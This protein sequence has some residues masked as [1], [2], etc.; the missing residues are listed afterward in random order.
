LGL[1]KRAVIARRILLGWFAFHFCLLLAVSCREA[2]WVV[3][4]GLTIFPTQTDRLWKSAEAI[5]GAGLGERLSLSN[6]L[7]QAVAGYQHMAG[8]ESGYGFF[9]PNVTNGYQLAFKIDY[10]D[11]HSD[12]EV[13]SLG[14]D[15]AGI[16]FAGLL[17]KIGRTSDGSMGETM[18]RMLT[19][20]KWR[21]HPKAIKIH[22]VFREV[23][24]PSAEEYEQGGRESYD[25]LGEYDFEHRKRPEQSQQKQL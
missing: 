8:I 7:R 23:G 16:R 21:E 22:A 6:P 25:V 5:A 18:I 12:Y 17:D 9:A 1:E 2:L 24:L 14:S 15:A 10:A 20:A 19:A 13:P 3:A 4:R 11:G